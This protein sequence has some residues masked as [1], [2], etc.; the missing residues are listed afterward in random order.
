MNA[1][2]TLSSSASRLPWRPAASDSES[3]RIF[4]GD[5]AG[6]RFEIEGLLLLA[7]QEAAS[8][9]LEPDPVPEPLRYLVGN[10]HPIPADFGPYPS[11]P[12]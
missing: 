11:N 10:W 9:E 6:D 3:P 4:Q 2:S 1:C 5:A 7:R 8:S 12:Y